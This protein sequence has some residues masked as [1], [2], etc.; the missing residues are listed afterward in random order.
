[1]FPYEK[2]VKGIMSEETKECKCE[3]KSSFLQDNVMT[4]L[5]QESTWRGLITVATLL[6]WRLAPD[7]AEAIITAGA[8]L[9][10]TINILKKD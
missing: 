2:K 7:Q 4:R 6:G 10:G 1:L 5:K 3:C 9:V 8:S